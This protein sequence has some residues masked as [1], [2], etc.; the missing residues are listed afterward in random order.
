MTRPTSVKIFGQKYKVKYDLH[1]DEAEKENMGLTDS[2][3]NTIRLMG[4]L[5]EDKMARVFMHEVTHAIINESTLSEKKR[6][7]VEEVCDIVGFHMVDTLKA[8]PA[9]VEWILKEEEE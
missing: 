8:N 5:Q 9:I 4:N 1:T 3:S 2:T 7:N 6:F